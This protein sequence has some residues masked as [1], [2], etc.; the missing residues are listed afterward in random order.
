MAFAKWNLVA[1]LTLHDLIVV[2][3]V[4]GPIRVF[5]FNVYRLEYF[6]TR[7]DVA[8]TAGKPPLLVLSL[9][10]KGFFSHASNLVPSNGEV[11]RATALPSG[12][13]GSRLMRKSLTVAPVQRFVM[14]RVPQRTQR[15]TTEPEPGDRLREGPRCGIQ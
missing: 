7:F 2:R 13:A 8:P 15:W 9:I 11:D 3:E 1:T 4:I 12:F 6:M 14:R 5:T 10:N